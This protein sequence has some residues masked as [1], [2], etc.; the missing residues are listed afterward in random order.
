MFPAIRLVLI[1]DLLEHRDGIQRMFALLGDES[2]R[3]G[4]DHIRQLRVLH[5]PV[6]GQHSANGGD[7]R[8]RGDALRHD[9]HHRL[10]VLGVEHEVLGF[11]HIAQVLRDETATAMRIN[12]LITDQTRATHAAL[13]SIDASE[14][15]R[16]L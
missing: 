5:L 7:G 4:H 2:R 9:D 15:L 13:R 12:M 14:F 1:D 3:L 6:L 8:W 16:L 11:H 10:Q